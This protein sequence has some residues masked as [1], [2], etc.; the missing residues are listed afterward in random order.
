MASMNRVFLVGNLTRD[1]EIRYTPGNRAVGDLRLAVSRRY[2]T[3]DGQDKEEV[4]YV[5]VVVWDRQAETCE[6]YLRKGSPVLVEGR[7]QYD[8]WE[9]DGQK[10]NRLRVTAERV[11]FLGGPGK[12]AAVSD[13]PEGDAPARE[14]DPPA[15]PRDEAPRSKA[16]AESGDDD[17]LP[18]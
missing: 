1:P 4:C 5:S 7:L 10:Q 17:N 12:T 9:K 2:K 8:E 11:Q 6:Q 14:P 16:K 15:P 3:K 13:T 18:F